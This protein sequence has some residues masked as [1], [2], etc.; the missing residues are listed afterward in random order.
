M[1]NYSLEIIHPYTGDTT[2]RHLRNYPGLEYNI[3][4]G[5]IG[6]L[7]PYTFSLTTAPSGMTI[8]AA[9]GEVTWANPVTSGSPH[10][11]TVHVVDDEA[12]TADVSWTITVSTSN[13]LFLDSVSGNDANA[14]TIASPKQTINGFYLETP[15]Y[16][17]RLDATY[18]GYGVIFRTGTYNTDGCHLE[19]PDRV[20]LRDVKPHIWLA[21]P[22]ETVVFD[23]TTG[24]GDASG[25]YFAPQGP[26]FYFDRFEWIAGHYF[27]LRVNTEGDA[28]PYCVIRRNTMHDLGLGG[29]GT[30]AAFIM[31]VADNNVG[32]TGTSRM[33][34]QDNEMYDGTDTCFLKLYSVDRCLFEDNNCH[35]LIEGA[36]TTGDAVAIKRSGS[37]FTVRGNYIHD[38]PSYTQAIGGNMHDYTTQ[39]SGEI[40]FNRCTGG[41]TSALINEDGLAAEVYTYRNTFMGSVLVQNVDSTDGPFT[42]SNNVIVNPDTGTPSGSHITHVSVTDASRVVIS[43]SP[44]GNL[45][46]VT[47][48]NIVDA[49]GS[50]LGSYRTLYLGAK[51]WELGAEPPN[52]VP[53]SAEL[54]MAGV[55]P[56]MDFGLKPETP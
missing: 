5:V 10:S 38:N 36:S 32:G 42:F 53:G 6:G 24:A 18:D 28:S 25:K 29:A 2:G 1:A 39:V 51:G 11:V 9:T 35:N 50:L 46:G 14:G 41:Q 43:A 54:V 4:L 21:Y 12:S 16:D 40:C 45:V 56:K 47:A 27:F 20:L 55:G 37:R 17:A 34:I 33:V 23:M 8:D 31:T 22:G 15:T 3:R 26:S 13:W 30:N 19:G 7:Y 48:D 49:S 52:Q 44:N